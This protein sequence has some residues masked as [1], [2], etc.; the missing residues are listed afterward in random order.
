MDQ[1]RTVDGAPACASA[2]PEMPDNACYLSNTGAFTCGPLAPEVA[3]APDSY[4]H[5]DRALPF[6]NGCA[7]GF[8]PIGIDPLDDSKTVCWAMC[9]P[10]CYARLAA[11]PVC[12]AHGG[13]DRVAPA[14]W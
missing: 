8:Q 7:P 13:P 14:G 2:N 6:I 5:M 1:T 10:R 4:R 11:R 3:A 9:R 12:A